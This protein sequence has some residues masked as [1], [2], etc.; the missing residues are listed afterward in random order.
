MWGITVTTESILIKKSYYKTI[1]DENNTEHPIKVLGERYLEEM[2]KEQ[3]DLSSIRFAQGEVYF[4]N[5]DFE[6]AIYKWQHPL[7]KQFVSWAQKNIA[8]A[9]MELGLLEYAE[10][11]YKEVETDSITLQSEVLL[12]LF[13]LYIQQGQQERSVR[14]IK[15]AV[16]LD[17]DYADVTEIAK[18]YFEDIQDWENAI[19]L[20]VNEAIRTESFA[21]FDVL[22]GYA[23]LDIIANYEPIY[24][25]EAL[26]T[27]FYLD[28]NRFERLTEVLW[29]SYEE[30]DFY[31]EWLEEMNQLL[32]NHHVE[33]SF[34][35]KKLP[36]L[37]KKAYFYLISGRFLI[38]DIS[39][40]MQIHLANWLALS[41]AADRLVSST[42]VLAWNESFPSELSADLIQDAEQQFEH[43]LPDQN[44]GQEGAELMDSIKEWAEKEGIIDGLT[45]FMKRMLDDNNME[46]ASPSQIRNL[47]KAALDYCLKQKMESE[48]V[49][50]QDINWNKEMLTELHDFQE[51]ISKMEKEK[52]KVMTDSFRDV[53]K[54]LIEKMQVKLPEIIRGCSEL[55]KE[56][57]D[58]SKIHNVLNEEMNRRIEQFMESNVLPDFR[59]ATQG[60]LEDSERE[61]QDSQMTCIQY[62]D[63]INEQFRE[64]KVVL[65]GDFKVLEDW[66]R[67]I[68]RT[69]RGLLRLEK[70]NILLRN[71][72]SQLLLKGAGKLLGP[73]SKNNDMILKRYKDYVENGDYNEVAKDIIKPFIQQ[74][75]LFEESIEWDVNRFFSDPQEVIRNLIQEVEANIEAHNG[76]LNM[77]REQPEIY[78]DP[79]RLFELKLR[80][81][82]LKNMINEVS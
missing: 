41:S 9:H 11:F 72:P 37:F 27:L 10:K 54:R 67:D 44:S 62:S 49:I 52:A 23:S 31:F 36:S 20:A 77:M 7:D 16:K 39:N 1:L 22:E 8:D 70:V 59:L 66:Q 35:W 30:S 71:N 5:S 32:M 51:H 64:D 3:P 13:S 50:L 6:A 68:N 73:L 46:M 69:S 57:A 4:L 40:L 75:E 21:W 47:I 79:I 43:S 29:N 76:S 17:P 63:Q 38:R 58:F 56:D 26:V 60:W 61:F 19:E 81:Y 78:R 24:F 33:E 42:A 18:R 55:V 80:H 48:N 53:K 65:S 25:N 14:T 28:K 82:E 15:D 45:E 74:L 34:S 12:Q 2:Q